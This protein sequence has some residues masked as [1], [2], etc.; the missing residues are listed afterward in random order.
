MTTQFSPVYGPVASW[1]YG[2]SLGID[3]IGPLSTCSFNCVYCQLGNIEHLSKKRQ[4]F[5]LTDEI[6]SAL[7]DFAPWNVDVITLSGSGEPTLAR[8]LREILDLVKG[9]THRPSAVL[10]NGTLLH[11]P[12]VC[13]ELNAADRVAIKIDA[14]SAGLFQ[15]INRPLQEEHPLYIW[16]G[17]AQFKQSYRGHLE[18]QT[19]ILTPWS[20]TEQVDYIQLM[21][22]IQPDEIQLNTPTRPRPLV[23]QLEARGNH[24]FGARP[25][26]VQQLKPVNPEFF[27]T[28]GDRIYHATEIP[29]RY[30]PIVTTRSIAGA[31]S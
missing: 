29:V 9:L 1:R 8:N 2:R 24:S 28:F 16:E 3:P 14:V 4:I 19:M 22:Q 10:T 15:R 5:V 7:R 31:R 30:A 6:E 25:Y 12:D 11:D 23:H 21:Q 26:P 13:Q 17:I 18:I 20:D 27:K